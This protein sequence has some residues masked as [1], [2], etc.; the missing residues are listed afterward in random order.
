M[1]IRNGGGKGEMRVNRCLQ[2]L[3]RIELW[4]VV[5][6]GGGARPPRPRNGL[7]F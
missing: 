4:R 5:V 6:P 1:T 3:E 7:T 2:G